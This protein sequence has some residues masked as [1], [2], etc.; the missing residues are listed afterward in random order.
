MGPTPCLQTGSSLQTAASFCNRRAQYRAALE[1]PVP[2]QYYDAF[3]PAMFYQRASYGSHSREASSSS[4]EV[5]M[6]PQND[7]RGKYYDELWQ[8]CAGPLVSVPKEGELVMYMP[9]G[10]IE[11]IIASTNPEAGCLVDL[12]K[13]DLSPH[14]LCKVMHVVLSADPDTDE[15]NAQLSLLPETKESDL[16]EAVEEEKMPTSDAAF[17]NK[18]TVHKFC[19]TLTA[20]DTSTHGGFS[21]PRKHA[22]CL[23]ALDMNR[24]TPMQELVATDLH[25]VKWHFRHIYRGQPKRHLL[26]TGWSVFVS[27]KKLVAGDAVIFL[28]AE[29]GELRVGIR[30]SMRQQNM[31]PSVLPSQS[32]QM[33]VIATATHAVITHTIFCI[34][35]K[36]RVSPAEFI[37]PVERFK[38]ALSVSLAVGM[39][40]RKRFE[41]EDTSERRYNGTITGIED[42]NSARWPSSKW[43]SLKVGWDEPTIQEHHDRVSPWEIELYVNPVTP[44]ICAPGPRCKRA[45]ANLPITSQA[46]EHS[47]VSS[48][49]Y[50]A[51]F[52]SMLSASSSM[53]LQGQ[54]CRSLSTLA[55]DE[56]HGSHLSIAPSHHLF[57]QRLPSQ[58]ST[59]PLLQQSIR[60][61]TQVDGEFWR[62]AGVDDRSSHP[63]SAY[64]TSQQKQQ[65]GLSD[66]S[67]EFSSGV[68]VPSRHQS[69]ENR[70]LV[71]S[72]QDS[73]AGLFKLGADSSNWQ[74]MSGYNLGDC[75][76]MSS[77][78]P[79]W[80]SN[81]GLSL[82]LP[83]PKLSSL[84]GATEITNMT[85]QQTMQDQHLHSVRSSSSSAW[86]GKNPQEVG[87][88]PKSASIAALRTEYKLFGFS[89]TD[90]PPSTSKDNVAN[91]TLME[92]QQAAELDS[93]QQEPEV[94]NPC[95]QVSVIGS[96][97]TSSE[98]GSQKSTTNQNLSKD[99]Q[100][101][102]QFAGR[103]CTKVVKKGSIVGR[104]VDLSKFRG[105]DQLFEEL[106]RMF[107]LEGQL[108]DKEKGWQVAYSD[109]END[110]LEVGDDPWG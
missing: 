45:R 10:H 20:S 92:K 109:D 14:I 82:P 77:S 9:Q 86:Q 27:Q 34:Y 16:Q 36:P 93:S 63:F 15:V 91:R 24:F 101:R 105:Y 12:P 17:S 104:G 5:S 47:L 74:T 53:V 67:L 98:P 50:N 25:G 49:R 22:S 30:R 21:V 89:L 78:S 51:G 65:Q 56:Y 107:H 7:S 48:G 37:I 66:V 59:L 11:Q 71:L 8:A 46:A 68:S 84:S 40:F 96:S 64:V 19:K 42:F 26:T 55:E 80:L 6:S 83:S 76:P 79:Y 95:K 97:T 38:G 108:G 41:T 81:P 57:P 100:C 2:T 29:D 85:S 90:P 73:T 4:D 13:H 88:E 54:N 3:V 102:G 110:M 52:E 70:P 1:Y 35:Y 39:R 60:G 99:G 62:M 72:N 69:S 28:R 33:G 87:T 58:G 43:R 61:N 75:L 31:P 32:L 94:E 106:E 23:P 103:S 44:P 18:L